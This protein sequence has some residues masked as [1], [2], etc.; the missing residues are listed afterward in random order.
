MTPSTSSILQT[1]GLRACLPPNQ[2]QDISL[3]LRTWVLSFTIREIRTVY[4]CLVCLILLTRRGRPSNYLLRWWE[5]A[6][7]I[8]PAATATVCE[9]AELYLYVYKQF[10]PPRVCFDVHLYKSLR[11]HMLTFTSQKLTTFLIIIT[12][13][14]VGGATTARGQNFWTKLIRL[15]RRFI[16]KH[17]FFNYQNNKTQRMTHLTNICKMRG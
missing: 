7:W 9:R 8:E 15:K 3:L 2:C 12:S 16:T 6:V 14:M 11:R 5:R 13:I 4:M 10:Q 1:L 17:S